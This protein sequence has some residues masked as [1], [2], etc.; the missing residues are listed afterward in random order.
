MKIIS[1]TKQKNCTKLVFLL[2]DGYMIENSIHYPFWICITTQVGCGMGCL[3]CKSG[4]MGFRRNLSFEEI[5]KQIELST[6]YCIGK[7]SYSETFLLIS[8]S[9]MG[10]PLMNSEN[11]FAA[12]TELQKN[13]DAI[14]NIT[15]SGIIDKFPIFMNITDVQKTYL[16]ISMHVLNPEKRKK[17][18]PVENKYPIKEVIK[19]IVNYTNCFRKIT[20]DYLLIKNFNDTEDDLNMLIRTFKNKNVNIEL[21]NYNK[22]LVDDNISSPCKDVFN[23][24][25]NALVENGINVIQEKS[26]GVEIGAGCGQLVWKLKSLI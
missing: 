11:V 20:F 3:F 2:D 6:E 21:K 10:E 16:D 17:L 14:I 9:G 18:M 26:E 7:F 4:A 13:T 19:Q 12:I 5:M 1:S 24:F 23:K 8:F 25:Q 22:A 15:T